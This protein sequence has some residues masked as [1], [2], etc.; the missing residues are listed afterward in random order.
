MNFSVGKEND[1]DCP[2]LDFKG[3]GDIYWHLLDN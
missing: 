1:L 3:K 2:G